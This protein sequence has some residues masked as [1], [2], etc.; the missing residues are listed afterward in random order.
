M[1]KDRA[2]PCER[3]AGEHAADAVADPLDFI[4]RAPLGARRD[5]DRGN[6]IAAGDPEL[7]GHPVQVVERVLRH[8]LVRVQ[9]A[10]QVA[11]RNLSRRY[12]DLSRS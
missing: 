7:A 9:L 4:D 8:P 5:P 6:R 11:E 2:T 1:D 10:G 3:A 12:M